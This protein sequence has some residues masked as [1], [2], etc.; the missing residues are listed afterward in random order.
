M[1]NADDPRVPPG[2]PS[3]LS[4]GT[5]IVH[6]G[7]SEG[8]LLRT[9]NPPIQRATTILAEKAHALYDGSQQTYSRKG[10][11]TRRTLERAIA[12]MEGGIGTRLYPSGLAA[13]AQALQALV[14]GGD[15]ILVAEH[16]YNPT[17]VFCERV[18]RRF[19]VDVEYFPQQA[20]VHEI[21]RLVTPNTRLV[22]LESPGS[23]SFQLQ[24]VPAIARMARA[25]G[26]LT[27]IDNTWAA[28]YLSRPLLQGVDLAIQS[29]SKYVGGHSDVLMGCVTCAD[30]KTL[31]VLDSALD[32]VGNAV[33]PEDAY[34]AQRSLRTLP[35]RLARHGRSALQIATWLQTQPEVLRVLHP[36]LPSS[37]DHALWRR[38][39]G[40]ASGL[41]GVVLKPTAERTVETVLDSLRIFGLGFSWGGHESLALHCDPQRRR[42]TLIP[43]YP[44]PLLR[45]HIGL[46]EPGDLIADLR[47][48]LDRLTS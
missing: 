13:I 10:L 15:R 16:V 37:P 32:D 48:G 22:Y 27:A 9:V 17:R 35:T 34:L 44:G 14:R 2:D 19:G 28:G 25:R 24:D 45:F 47:R 5:R 20:P 11:V 30:R 26:L 40:G 12:E 8:A 33:S 18:L 29:L 41:F 36:A 7:L 38:D 31:D 23:L 4:E 42:G 46:E 43:D 39:F 6:S 1:A 3:S 21:E